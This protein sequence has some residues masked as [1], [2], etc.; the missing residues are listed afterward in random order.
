[1]TT[2]AER[3]GAFLTIDLGAIADN[4]RKLRDRLGGAACA[5]VVKADA[6]GL[7][8][9][10]VAPVLARAGCDTFFV[11]T[12]DE[13]IALRAAVADAT[14]AV[15]N[16]LG[17]GC[18]DDFAGHRITPVLND[19]GQ[20]DC[21][22]AFAR[23][24]GRRDAMIHLDTGMNRLGLPAAEAGEL[25]ENPARLDGLNVRLIMSHLACAEDRNNPMN[26]AQRDRFD[27]LRRKL[28]TAPA[29][30]ANSSGVF[31]GPGYHYD[32]ARPGVALYGVNP[33]P[34]DP[35]PMKEV[36]RLQGRIIQLRDVDTSQTVGYGAAHKVAAPGRIATVPVGYADGF[37][38][39]LGNR[40]S[41]AIGDER[42]PVVGRVSMDLITLDVSKLPP[43]R[44]VPG[45]LVDLIGGACPID[46]VAES[47][48]TIGYELLTSLGS[49]YHRL[50][51]GDVR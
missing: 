46:R 5:A 40:A 39:S 3:A 4:W 45:T 33:T 19:L 51:V 27:A 12:L 34:G 21:W 25:A 48:G 15:L 10:A 11:A 42:V 31:L 35:N 32:M 37:L 28:P 20:I 47:A 43:D 29:S 38:R 18:E 16:G 22:S 36:V 23:S 2:E 14:V 9:A 44:A 30:L 7:G 49:R 13:A 50:Y 1:M 24:H 41:A 8:A 17:P 26:A 6:Y